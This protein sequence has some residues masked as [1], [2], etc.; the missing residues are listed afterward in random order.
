MPG[1]P[2]SGRGSHRRDIRQLPQ[3]LHSFAPGR[4]AAPRSSRPRQHQPA[5][6][7]RRH[8]PRERESARG[9]ARD[10]VDGLELPRNPSGIEL[11]ARVLLL[12]ARGKNENAEDGYPDGRFTA[13]LPALTRSQRPPATYAE[14]IVGIRSAVTSKN[15]DQKP[16]GRSIA[17]C[18]PSSHSRSDT[19]ARQGPGSAAPGWQR[20][21]AGPARRPLRRPHRSGSQ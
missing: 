17:P 15:R 6:V 11:R 7:P 19:G 21:S 2:S 13:V 20:K 8:G 9:D 10:P 16:G 4:T 12:A 14:P 5:G 18:W 1:S 3:R